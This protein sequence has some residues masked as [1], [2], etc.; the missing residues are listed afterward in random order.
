MISMSTT[1]TARIL[2]KVSASAVLINNTS[3]ISIIIILPLFV[4]SSLPEDLMIQ[5][6]TA[7]DGQCESAYIIN[8]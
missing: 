3:L 1:M 6:V 8:R 2:R 5:L 7:V 4:I